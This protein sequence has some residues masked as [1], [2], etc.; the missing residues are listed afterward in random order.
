MSAIT[1]AM[2]TGTQP[3][4]RV[5]ARVLPELFLSGELLGHRCPA[6]GAPSSSTT[7]NTPN[8]INAS[9]VRGALRVVS[10]R[11][12][13]CRAVLLTGPRCAVARTRA[14]P[15]GPVAQIKLK[16]FPSRAS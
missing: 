3:C 2:C 9:A 11:A 10:C 1:C 16:I 5:T 15:A 4:Q 7:S 13:P 14:A 12:E 6:V 8:S